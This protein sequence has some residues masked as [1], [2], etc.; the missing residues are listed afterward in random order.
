MQITKF[1]TI[2]FTSALLLAAACNSDD[3]TEAFE[4]G[5]ETGDGDG[6]PTTGDGDPDTGDGD[7]DTGDGDPDTGDGDPDTGDG[8]PDTGDGDPD[9]GDG[10]PDTGDGDPDTGDGDPDTGDGDPDTGDGDPDTGDGDPDTGSDYVEIEI[11]AENFDALPN[12]SGPSTVAEFQAA[13]PGWAHH[14]DN[15]ARQIGTGSSTTGAIYSF[16]ASAVAERALGGVAS[17]NT[18]TQTWGV[19]ITNNTS[20]DYEDIMVSYVGEQWRAA[21]SVSANT[22][23]FAYTT[24]TSIAGD[25]QANVGAESGDDAAIGWLD[26]AALHFVSPTVSDAGAIDGND[27]ANRVAISHTIP[28][29]IIAPSETLCIRWWDIDNAGADHGLAVDDLVV[30]A[31]T[32][33]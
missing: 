9:T 21:N 12:V 2:T 10:D 26:V 20:A 22:L 31:M 27:D 18:G 7:P 15:D 6:D 29:L 30:T 24:S 33:Q 5:T 25:L 32:L 13:L 23:M 14:N 1:R 28:D 3:V 16:G 19:C 8:D 17:G 11:L 4:T